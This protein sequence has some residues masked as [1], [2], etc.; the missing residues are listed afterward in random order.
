VNGFLLGVANGTVCLAY[1]AP[2]LI[3][4]FLT[5]AR[6]IGQNVRTLAQFLAGRLAGYLIFGTVAWAAGQ[7]LIGSAAYR[8]LLFGAAYVGLAVLLA[9]YAA[10]SAPASCAASAP[11]TRRLLARWPRMMAAGLGFL[12]GLNLCPPFLMAVTD[13]A[14]TGSLLDSLIFFGAF[15]L[16]T[17][18]YFLPVPVLGHFRYAESLRVI[19]RFAAGLTA[20]YYLYSGAI[21]FAGGIVQL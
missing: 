8:P 3:P 6:P 5:E 12:T 9:V 1:C 4:F 17:S 16:G 20:L 10:R 14:S 7:A 19:G 13:A 11:L 18:L 15:F 21:L 2:V